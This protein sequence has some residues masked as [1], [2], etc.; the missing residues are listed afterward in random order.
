MT[1]YLR[2]RT[3]YPPQIDAPPSPA[4]GLVVV[5][6]AY[7]EPELTDSLAALSDCTPPDCDVEVIVVINE[8]EDASEVT[9][10]HNREI[11][12]IARRWAEQQQRQGFRCFILHHRLPPKHAG[13]GLARKIGMDEAC[14]RLEQAGHSDGIIACFDADS[15][16][17]VNYLQALEAHFFAHPECPACSIYFEHPL[18]GDDFAPEVY[19]AIVQYELHLRYYIQIQRWV[20]FPHAFHTV[21]SSMAVRCSAY[22]QQ[23]GMNRRKAGEDFYF[24]HKFTPL[25][26]FAELNAT[27]VIP[28]PRPSY[29]VPFGTGRAVQEMM[30]GDGAYRSYHP[31]SFAELRIFLKR[32]PDFYGGAITQLEQLIFPPWLLTFLQDQHFN[33]KLAEIRLHS[34]T[35]E[36]FCDRFFRWF[37]AFMVMKYV[38]FVRDQG[39]DDLP[40]EEAAAWLL[41]TTQGRTGGGNARALLAQFR[42]VDRNTVV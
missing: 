27:R 2:E 6:P 7:E 30:A 37:N 34:T 21:G 3:L 9:V 19:D 41:P 14:R 8:P 4:L 13:V 10:A 35:S 29:R 12:A 40:T 38:H 25:S 32:L 16:C 39:R 1:P 18:E 28:S 33:E 26:G 31:L 22:Q 20:G 23:G 11:A 24:I 42:Q 36:T 17:D 5:I 15:R